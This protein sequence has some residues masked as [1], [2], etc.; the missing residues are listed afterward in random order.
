MADPGHR[1]VNQS[2]S[3]T[4]TTGRSGTTPGRTSVGGT[5]PG[6]DPILVCGTP[7]SGSW[8]LCWALWESGVTTKPTECLNPDQLDRADLN[9]VRSN[10]NRYFQALSPTTGKRLLAKIHFDDVEGVAALAG[11]GPD[12]AVEL[13]RQL[14]LGL[15]ET[16]HLVLLTRKNKLRQALSLWRARETGEW[17]RFS[18]DPDIG[19]RWPEAQPTPTAIWGLARTL[20]QQEMAWRRVLEDI[21]L[22]VYHLTYEE[23]VVDW[24]EVH[25]LWDW[26]GLDSA[27]PR[28]PITARQS[29]DHSDTLLSQILPIQ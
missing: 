29:D 28:A 21:P 4:G 22:D 12:R 20:F 6:C 11:R 26:L 14:L 24:C 15:P 9:V 7:R 17:E 19:G 23:V 5:S 27:P 8:M 16:A 18:S 10:P 13:C 25:R 3:S 1:M 2:S